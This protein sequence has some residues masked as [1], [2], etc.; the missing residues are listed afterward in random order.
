MAQTMNHAFSVTNPEGAL[1]FAR[2]GAC[3]DHSGVDMVNN[4]HANSIVKQCK[5]AA[6]VQKLLARQLQWDR[7]IN[8][9]VTGPKE[10]HTQETRAQCQYN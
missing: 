2:N 8:I 9:I 4:G 5:S 3:R 7:N 1:T 10:S 6:G